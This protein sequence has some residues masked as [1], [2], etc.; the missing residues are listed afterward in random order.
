M[1]KI[2]EESHSKHAAVYTFDDGSVVRVCFR[3]GTAVDA[4]AYSIAG[5]NAQRFLDTLD[6]ASRWEGKIDGAGNILECPI[7]LQVS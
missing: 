1:R 7:K 5:I 3:P 6:P 4:N 2:V